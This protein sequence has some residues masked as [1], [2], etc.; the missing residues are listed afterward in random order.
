ML[1]SQNQY[2][3]TANQN[4]MKKCSVI[5]TLYLLI[6]CLY[7]NAQIDPYLPDPNPPTII[8]GYTLNWSDEFNI[9]GKPDSKNWGYETGFLR[10]EEAQW[11]QMNNAGCLDGALQISGKREH[12]LNP[13][14]NSSSSDWRFNRHYVE[15][16]SASLNTSGL[17][18]WLYGTFIV[19]AK[20][21]T[22]TGSWPAIWTLGV[23]QE[24]PSNGEIDI[25]EFY[26]N[27]ILANAAWGTSTRWVANWKST[28]T[29][30]S[31]FTAKDPDWAN[32]YHIWR[33]DWTSR[34]IKLYLDNELLNTID[35]ATTINA[36]GTNPFHQAQYL[37][38]NLAIGGI[39]GG[40]PAQ[41]PFPI[42][43]AVDYARVYQENSTETEVVKKNSDPV[44]IGN[45]LFLRENSNEV[46]NICIFEP[47][48]KIVLNQ[49]IGA[50]IKSIDVSKLKKGI[51]L[52]QLNG[53]YK[54]SKFI[55]N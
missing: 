51:Y 2:L 25:M 53:N 48:G 11:Y 7:V 39:N 18:S 4:Q 46:Q 19:R 24:W 10:N 52:I 30:F 49:T 42:T 54:T 1:S 38:L 34:Y 22:V 16:T 45:K 5:S 27:S 6:G 15:Y 21:P 28:K 40:D 50:N 36:N 12:Y 13:T 26:A 9:N 3:L 41:T 14:Y 29:P 31:H 55:K 8:P 44:L 47:T 23:N 33:M 43:Y 35:V 20:I 17:H 37:L 32:K